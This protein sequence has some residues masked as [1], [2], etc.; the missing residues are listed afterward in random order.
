MAGTWQLYLYILSFSDPKVLLLIG[1]LFIHRSTSSIHPTAD[2]DRRARELGS[3]AGFGAKPKHVQ[4]LQ[5]AI[6]R[7]AKAEGHTG[8]FL[9]HS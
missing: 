1:C 3:V 7:S 6:E 4:A 2:R 5:I 9:K 8:R